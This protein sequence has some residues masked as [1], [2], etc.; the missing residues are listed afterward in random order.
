MKDN[1]LKISILHWLICSDHGEGPLQLEL[2]GWSF[3]IGI[4]V[5]EVGTGLTEQVS[6]LADQNR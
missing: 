4:V 5:L 6:E 3:G 1:S 2:I